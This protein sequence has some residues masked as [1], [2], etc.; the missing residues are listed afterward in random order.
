MRCGAGKLRYVKR[1]FKPPR[2]STV[3]FIGRLAKDS[4]GLRWISSGAPMSRLWM[5]HE[6]PSGFGLCSAPALFRRGGHRPVELG[7]EPVAQ[8]RRLSGE[9]R[10]QRRCRD[11]LRLVCRRRIVVR[12]GL[13]PNH[14]QAI[15]RSPPA[16]GDVP[17]GVADCSSIT[18][19]GQ[20]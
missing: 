16:G 4:E 2:G 12:P 13:L 5:R 11:R 15:S 9:V 17:P 20:P 8:E 10:G 7:R 6:R 1:Q 14:R 19:V 3:P 18:V